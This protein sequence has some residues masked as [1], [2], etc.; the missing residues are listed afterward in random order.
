MQEFWSDEYPESLY[1]WHGAKHHSPLVEIEKCAIPTHN[2]L[3]S[4]QEEIQRGHEF[5]KGFY[6]RMLQELTYRLNKVHGLDFSVSFWQIAFGY[7]LYRH[8]S[9]IYDKYVYLSG[10]DIDYTGIKLLSKNDFFIPQ[11]HNDYIFCFAG[12][13]G[14]QQLVSQYYYLFKT[15]NFAVVNKTF[16]C[17]DGSFNNDKISN[18]DSISKQL[19]RIKRKISL[20]IFEPQVAMLGVYLGEK[21]SNLLREKSHGKIGSIVL[22]MTELNS[23]EPDFEKRRLISD[24]LNDNTFEN[25]FFQSLYYCLP[26]DFLENFVEYITLFQRDIE[27]RKFTHIVAETWISSIPEGIYLALAKKNKRKFICY[28]HGSGAFYYQ[29]YMQF[30]DYDAADIYLSV[31]WRGGNNHHIR[32]GFTCRDIVPYKHVPQKIN[33][34]L[35][36]RTKFIYWEEFNEYNATNSTFLKEVKVVADIIYLFPPVLKKH[37]VFRPRSVAFLWDVER[38]LEID[39]LN[40]RIDRGDF[41]ESISSSRIVIIDHMSTGFSELLLMN[42][43]FVLVYDISLIPLSDELREVFSELT[44]CGVVHD[45]AQSAVSFLST[46]YDDVDGWWHNEA[47]VH[48]IKKLADLSLAP[49]N[50]STEFLLSLLARNVVRSNQLFDRLRYN[51]SLYTIKVL[52]WVGVIIS[53]ILT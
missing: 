24:S 48:S 28:E 21:T 12:D 29:N 4:T 44:D 17:V 40:I 47:V 36:T 10:L 23:S 8:I 14:V 32:G 6:Y 3:F 27:S 39:K 52:E 43:P 41:S 35:I 53:R 15:K 19:K 7:W 42:V 16:T 22:P 50:K 25:Y 51:V 38:L 1:L 26:K 2:D 33:I 20:L 13:F 11:N 5:C 45:T 37:L 46:I 9:V 34:L 18:N 30:I 31:G 49:A